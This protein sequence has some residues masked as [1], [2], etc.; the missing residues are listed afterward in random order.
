MDNSTLKLIN[1]LYQ[2][3]Q[4]MVEQLHDFCSINSGTRNLHG[5]ATM[6]QALQA[7]FAHI[8]DEIIERPLSPITTIN[9]SGETTLQSCG[10]AIFIRKR[11]SLTRRILLCGHMDTVYDALHPF[12]TLQYSNNT[13]H[14][15]GPGVADMKGGLVVIIHALQAFEKL[16][17][18]QSIGWDVFINSDEEIGSPSSRQH[19]ATIT[20]KYQTALVYEPSLDANGTFARNRKGSLKLTLIAHGVAAH[21][22]RAFQNGRNAICYLAQAIISIDALNNQR[23]GVTINIGKIAGGDAVNVVPATA[24]AKLDIRITN[25]ADEL[26]FKK[27]LS[28]IIKQLKHPDYTLKVDGMFGRPAKKVNSATKLLFQRIKTIGQQ[29]NLTFDWQDSGGCCDGNNLAQHG[30]AV[31]DTLG[32][33]GGNIHSP[34]EYIILDSLAERA[35]LSLLILQDLATG[36]LEAI[37]AHKLQQLNYQ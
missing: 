24:V 22:G 18:A 28:I 17:I 14:L 7:A 20:A 31:I 30:L 21:A 29:L 1:L 8:G 9:M 33:R 16:S 19:L 5:L 2:Q 6:Q 10:N 12:H 25:Q 37:A 11:P 26:W 27:E 4:N 35:A 23:P 32:V 13:K 36:S 3:Q 34:Q 15:N